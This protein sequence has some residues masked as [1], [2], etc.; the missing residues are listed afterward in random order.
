MTVIPHR[1]NLLQ[2]RN[3]LHQLLLDCQQSLTEKDQT[4]IVS[5]SQEISPVDPLA[6]LQEIATPDD[7]H[8]YFEK[9]DPI[10]GNSFAIAALD[11][12]IHLT[13][14]GSDRFALAQNFIQSCL[15]RTITIGTER[16]PFSGP[17]FFCS[18]AFFDENVATNSYFPPGTVF[19]PKWQ[20]TRLKDSCIIVANAIINR[21]INVKII[22]ENIF[23]RFNKIASLNYKT[24]KNAGKSSICLKQIPMNDAAQFKT[25]VKSALEL[26][27][28]KYFSKIVLS[29]AVNVI[30]Q[31]PFS[32][33]DS[34][35]NLRLT[36]PGCY[37]FSTSNGKGQNFIGASPE[38][39][40]SIHNNQLIADAL[41]GS[42]PRGKTEAEDGNLGKDLLNSEKDIRE[43]QAVI[44]F[45]VDRLSHLGIHPDFSPLPRLL[46]LSNIQHLWTPITAKIPPDI[47]LLKVLAQLHP[48]PAVAGVPRDIALQQIRGG[49]S[50]DRSLY[51]APLGWID[52][53]GNGE[54]AVGIRSA[55][56]D[57]SR[58]IL[59]A[60]VG[61][62]AGSEPEKELAE[63][64][65]KLQALLNALV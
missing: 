18:F 26:I 17:H 6:V 42:A 51:A 38:R 10:V 9:R 56:I 32:V 49:E 36:Y 46:Q 7:R 12:A 13:V 64:Q 40:I 19:L 28:S 44:D 14:A 22:T 41:A 50:C 63:I 52:R 1:A 5:I 65:L 4:K 29:Q 23:Q 15:A 53:T 11:S 43:H 3:Q 8:F 48:T 61:I 45:I 62:V 58:A 30:G 25:S 21:D 16:L 33:I 2:D 57:G 47:H 35:N 31:T 27:E 55:L 60:G 24:I 20:I 54:F 37:V 59:H 39:L 34:L